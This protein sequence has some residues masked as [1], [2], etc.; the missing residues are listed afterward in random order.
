VIGDLYPLKVGQSVRVDL[1]ENGEDAA[2]L[3]LT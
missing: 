2:S 1:D 3:A